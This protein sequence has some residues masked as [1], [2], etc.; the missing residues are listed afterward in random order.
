[1]VQQLSKIFIGV[2]LIFFVTFFS[3]SNT[4]PSRNDKNTIMTE[5]L[6][7]GYWCHITD[8]IIMDVPIKGAT[9]FE[10]KKDNKLSYLLSDKTDIV[11]YYGEWYIYNNRI[12]CIYDK[13]KENS[14]DGKFEED[15]TLD[16][17]TDHYK[18][19]VT[20]SKL[21]LID[22]NNKRMVFNRIEAKEYSSYLR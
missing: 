19:E 1:M 8:T 3:C 14:P 18:Y 21:I 17:I 11:E 15:L 22:S 13:M 7:I 12:N 16:K 4:F 6:L 2:M 20:K 5:N 9:L 10:F